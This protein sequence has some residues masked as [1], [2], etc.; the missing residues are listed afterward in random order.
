MS[1]CPSCR[2]TQPESPSDL[3]LV[4]KNGVSLMSMSIGHPPSLSTLGMV[5]GIHAQPSGGRYQV[6]D[7]ATVALHLLI[8]ITFIMPVIIG[9]GSLAASPISVARLLKSAP[10]VAR[11]ATISCTRSRFSGVCAIHP[12]MRKSLSVPQSISTRMAPNENTSALAKSHG[13]PQGHAA[14]GAVNGQV[15]RG[16]PT[17]Q[18]SFNAKPK[19]TIFGVPSSEIT[20]FCG[21]RSQWASP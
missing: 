20:I 13:L 8:G 17:G 21:L 7:A 1:G 12:N 5:L 11:N 4:P 6:K 14:S 15:P 16:L 9:A 10:G 2:T 18:P 3:E 19:S